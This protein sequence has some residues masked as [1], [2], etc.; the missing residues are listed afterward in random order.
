M[1]NRISIRAAATDKARMIVIEAEGSEDAIVALTC[2]AV[3]FIAGK[4]GG[5]GPP[6]ALPPPITITPPAKPRRRRR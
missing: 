6:I 3:E 4:P 1:T 5:G 2:A